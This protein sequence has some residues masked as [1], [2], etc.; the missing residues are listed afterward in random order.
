[1]V[2]GMEENMNTI[3]RGEWPTITFKI[4]PLHYK[5]LKR[6][7]K[8]H[9]KLINQINRN[10]MKDEEP[11]NGVSVQSLCREIIEVYVINSIQKREDR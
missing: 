8:K 3:S 9:N 2:D 11:L 1:M 7:T 5:E 4:S 10:L 6:L